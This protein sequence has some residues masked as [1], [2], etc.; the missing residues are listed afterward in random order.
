MRF[1]TVV[2]SF[3]YLA[4]IGMPLTVWESAQAEKRP[5]LHVLDSV[6]AL[7]FALTE[8]RM[9]CEVY[10]VVGESASMNGITSVIGEE[11]PDA[12]VIITPTPNLDQVSYELDEA[13]SNR[14]VSNPDIR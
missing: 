6:S 5:Y 10:D 3:T 7:S 8:N 11:V 2:D 1:D 13:R 12:E 4:C 9:K 14:S